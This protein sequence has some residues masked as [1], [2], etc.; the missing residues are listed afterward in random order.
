[1]GGLNGIGGGL[2]KGLMHSI[3][4]TPAGVAAPAGTGGKGLFGGLV[5]RFGDAES[6]KKLVDILFLPF[7]WAFFHVIKVALSTPLG[8]LSD[9]IGRKR[10]ITAGWAVYAFVYGCFAVVDRLPGAWQVAATLFLFAVYAFYYAFSEGAE[11]A[12]VADVVGPGL[13]GSAFGMYHFAVGLGALPAS[14]LF[15]VLYKTFGA[16]AAFGT[17]A[18]IALVSMALLAGPMTLPVIVTLELPAS[19]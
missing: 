12:F 6:Q 13:R 8:A 4:G 5:G 2:G 17:G 10:V 14:V 7:V 3:S 16:A 15:G 11:K 18:A 9:R 19:R 1:M